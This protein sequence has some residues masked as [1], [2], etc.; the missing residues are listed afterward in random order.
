MKSLAFSKKIAQR[1]LWSKRSEAFITILTVISVLGIAIG[2][3]VITMVMAIMTGF[4]YELREKIVGTDSHIVVNRWV[5][6]IDNWKDIE[7]KIQAVSGV[8]SVSAFSVSQVLVRVNSRSNGIYVRGVERDSAAGKQLQNYLEA[9]QTLEQAFSKRPVNITDEDGKQ[10]VVDLPGIIIGRELSRTLSVALGDAVS[11]FSPTVTSTPFGLIPRY[12]R[13]VVSGT[14]SSGLREYENG[15]AYMPLDEAQ[16]FF[17]LGDTVSGF[18][19]R[20][21]N[22]ETSNIVAKNILDSLA[23]VAGGGFEAQ[24]WRERNRPLLEAMELEKRVYFWVLLLLIM[25]GSFSI[26]S[27]LVMI[28]LEKRKDIAIL[29]T[30]GASARSI[31]RIFFIQGSI[32][33]IIGTILG[34]IGGYAGSILLKMYGFRLPEAFPLATVPI[35]LETMNFVSVGIASLLICFLATIYPAFRASRLQPTEVLRYE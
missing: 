17:R 18:E 6:K 29:R 21:K 35:K 8:E 28:V 3:T 31:A 30:L 11:L 13:F 25:M 32:I 22:V 24:D 4:E 34:L 14:Y 12:K 5:G 15:L 23:S 10:R 16:D 27:T 7:S 26:V 2:V 9:D 19:V 20:V 1:Y 33:G